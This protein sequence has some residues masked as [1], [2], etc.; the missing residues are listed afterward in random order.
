[1]DAKKLMLQTDERF[2]IMLNKFFSDKN[3][4]SNSKHLQ[5][6]TTLSAFGTYMDDI[7]ICATYAAISTYHEQLR[8]E[9][10]HRGIEIGSF[11]DPDEESDPNL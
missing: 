7:L 6:A 8:E 1:M 9:L 4:S 3:L 10:L 5:P 2:I 11:I